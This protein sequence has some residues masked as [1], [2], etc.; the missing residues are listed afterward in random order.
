MFLKATARQ[1][2]WLKS[3]KE[4][5]LDSDMKEMFN[6]IEENE[7]LIINLQKNREK[8]EKMQNYFTENFWEQMRNYKEKR[9][10]LWMQQ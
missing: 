3:L 6:I 8:M 2:L 1:K 9:K 7:K 5:M 10:D 4:E